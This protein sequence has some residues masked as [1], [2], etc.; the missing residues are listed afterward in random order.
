MLEINTL[1][2]FWGFIVL[3]S[4]DETSQ[5]DRLR[6]CESL[7]GEGC[8]GLMKAT[9][10]SQSKGL[11]IGTRKT[12]STTS[13][14]QLLINGILIDFGWIFLFFFNAC[15]LNCFQE[16]RK[17]KIGRCVNVHQK[18]MFSFILYFSFR[19]PPLII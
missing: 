7:S 10:K 1:S 6:L 11:R 3:M 19:T 14:F 13:R 9:L 5:K 8:S 18:Q 4:F 16:K 12:S 15:S 17:D 2:T